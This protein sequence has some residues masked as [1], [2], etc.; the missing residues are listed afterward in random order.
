MERTVL[1]H[2]IVRWVAS[3]GVLVA[4]WGIL[5]RRRHG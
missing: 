5:A 2:Q 1:D 3:V 4:L